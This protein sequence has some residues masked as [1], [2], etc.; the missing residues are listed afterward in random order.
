MSYNIE[1]FP[2]QTPTNVQKKINDAGK[3]LLGIF[4]LAV[5]CFGV[6]GLLHYYQVI[7]VPNIASIVQVMGHTW[8]QVSF[9]VFN[10]GGLFVGGGLIAST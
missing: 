4:L 3:T 7:A 8:F 5:A 6:S 2:Y 10:I 1:L 9:W